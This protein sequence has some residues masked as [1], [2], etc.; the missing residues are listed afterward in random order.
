M[1]M[2]GYISLTFSIYFDIIID[3]PKEDKVLSESVFL[4]IEKKILKIY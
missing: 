3:R 1:A 4:G 2:I